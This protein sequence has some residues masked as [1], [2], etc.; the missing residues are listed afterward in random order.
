MGV[1]I[2]ALHELSAIDAT[3]IEAACVYS[4]RSQRIDAASLVLVTSMRPR[5]DLYQE[6]L[7]RREAWADHGI[8]D[9]TCV[10]DC[11]GPGTIAAAVWSGH[12]YAR[13]LGAPEPDPVAFDRDIFALPA[14]N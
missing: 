3:G 13:T 9:V 1:E 14:L 8:Q 12:K 2:L 5:D 10:G 6:L 7:T 4:G 11:Y